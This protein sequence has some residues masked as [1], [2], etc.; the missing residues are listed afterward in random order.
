MEETHFSKLI[1]L[2]GIDGAGTTTQ[3]RLLAERLRAYGKPVW[4]TS[5]PTDGPVGRLVRRVLRGETAVH[6]NTMAHLYA[7]DRSEHVYGSGGIIEHAAAGEVVVCDRYVYS[8][9]AYQ[10]V[11]SDPRLIVRLNASFPAPAV[12]VFVDVPVK[13]TLRRLAT[14]STRE[15]FEYEAFQE[16][17]RDAYTALFASAAGQSGSARGE[18][19]PVFVST[20]HGVVDGTLPEET[21]SGK[22]WELLAQTSILES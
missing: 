9:L 3:G 19:S 7:A 17:V 20:V 15:I 8:S 11:E 5:E 12:A 2:E 21:V 18:D 16:S 13:V 4:L 1:V 6:P 22:V 14:R 10:T